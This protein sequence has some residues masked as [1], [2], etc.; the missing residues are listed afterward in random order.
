[1]KISFFSFFNEIIFIFN[2]D[3]LFFIQVEDKIVMIFRY[4][5]SM[6]LMLF[7]NDF[8]VLRFWGNIQYLNL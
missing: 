8:F 7:D 5:V 3:Y 1:M 4:F 6:D 2:W